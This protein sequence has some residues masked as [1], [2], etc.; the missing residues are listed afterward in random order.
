MPWLIFSEELQAGD[1]QTTDV[2]ICVSN[3]P[4]LPFLMLHTGLQVDQLGPSERKALCGRVP[5]NSLVE[6]SDIKHLKCAM[7]HCFIRVIS[8]RLRACFNFHGGVLPCG[9]QHGQSIAH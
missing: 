5:K 7:S 4:F 8:S 9:E 1:R 6:F 2:V 3:F